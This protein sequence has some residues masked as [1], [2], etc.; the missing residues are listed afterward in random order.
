[1]FEKCQKLFDPD[2][3]CVG[4]GEEQR[5]P[6]GWPV[7]IL[8]SLCRSLLGPICWD[9]A[10]IMNLAKNVLWIPNYSMRV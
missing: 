6:L 4:E 1:M 10:I 8:F 3:G 5:G 7:M 2:G 9:S